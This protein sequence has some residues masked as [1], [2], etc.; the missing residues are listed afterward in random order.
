MPYNGPMLELL[1]ANQGIAA[2]WNEKV[3]TLFSAPTVGYGDFPD[4][5][6]IVTP[7]QN[8][9]VNHKKYSIA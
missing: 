4:S 5:F 9:Q 8:W 7:S 3:Y 2:L 6:V 1:L